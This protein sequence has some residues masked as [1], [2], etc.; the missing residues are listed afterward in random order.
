M[1]RKRGGGQ[2]KLSADHYRALGML[3]RRVNGCTESL[4]RAHGI[5]L[6]TLC[7]LVK[8]QF[9]VAILDSGA[10]GGKAFQ[11]TRFQITPAG[12]VALRTL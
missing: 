8:E 1:E 11:V 4:M 6:E 12:R 7:S 9:A 2:V 10:A 5:K 3:A